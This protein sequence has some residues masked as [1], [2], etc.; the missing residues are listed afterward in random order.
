MVLNCLLILWMLVGTKK[1]GMNWHSLMYFVVSMHN[2][3]ANLGIQ[4]LERV[5]DKVIPRPSSNSRPKKT[6]YCLNASAIF[7]C[8]IHNSNQRHAKTVRCSERSCMASVQMR[9]KC[10]MSEGDKEKRGDTLTP[11]NVI[12]W[13]GRLPN[14]EASEGY[15]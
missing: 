1:T 13:F 6:P 5:F 2:F 14:A 4:L 9:N 11:F 3:V 10:R 12:S 7:P 8:K 15:V